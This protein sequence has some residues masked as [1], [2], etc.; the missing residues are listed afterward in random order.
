MAG[1]A[2]AIVLAAFILAVVFILVQSTVLTVTNN[3]TKNINSE[4]L[5]IEEVRPGE[6]EEADLIK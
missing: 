2:V 3:I 1:G 4:K 5:P 6:E